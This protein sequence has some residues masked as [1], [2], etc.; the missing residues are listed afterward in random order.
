METP[1]I[2]DFHCHPSLRPYGKSFTDNLVNSPNVKE[3]NSIY[4]YSP[5][6]LTDKLLNIS[7]TITRFSQSDFTTLKKGKLKVICASLYPIEKG[8]LTSRLGTGILPDEISNF[9]TGIGL[10]RIEFVQTNNDYFLDLQ[11][12]EN[13]FRQLHG[14]PVNTGDNSVQ[15]VLVK[16]T[17]QIKQNI[18]NTDLHTISVI[19][20]IEGSHA[21][22]G[23][24]NQRAEEYEILSNIEKLKNWEYPPFYITLAHHFYNE[25]CGHAQS[26]SGLLNKVL[27]Q[28]HGMNTGFTSLGWKVL[29]ALLDNLNGKRIF[30]DIKHMSV[31]SRKEYYQ[32]LDN[33]TKIPIIVSHGAVNG[34]DSVAN[35]QITTYNGQNIF[36][37]SDINIFDDEILKISDSHGIFCL[38]LDERIVANK[39]ILKNTFLTLNRKKMLHK[40]AGLIWNQI[41]HIAETLDKNGRNAWNILAIGS[42]FDGIVDPLNGYWTSEDLCMLFDNL[43]IYA[44]NYMADNRKNLSELSNRQ[45]EPEEIIIN[46]RS[47]NVMLFL[48]TYFR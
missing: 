40:K 18:Q 42:D 27:D 45:I 37:S 1:L 33:N 44:R 48:E 46:I 11:N 10:E 8:F 14:I 4:N 25:I 15:Y 26:L 9:V 34:F 29:D 19:P 16:N 43:L 23:H 7:S 35:M 3:E 38:Q 24:N 2:I 6:T 22:N 12:E 28:N 21:F 13:F 41:R 36:N 5:P 31:K 47:G 39:E 17:D 30:I 32:Y 20:T